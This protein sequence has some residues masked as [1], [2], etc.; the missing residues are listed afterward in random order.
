MANYL[1]HDKPAHQQVLAELATIRKGQAVLDTKMQQLTESQLRT[2]TYINAQISKDPEL[3]AIF[4]LTAAKQNLQLAQ[5]RGDLARIEEYSRR[6]Q[7]YRQQLL[8]YG[9]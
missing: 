9:R 7:A 5:E 1:L 6:V 4:A 8:P 2:N 3:R